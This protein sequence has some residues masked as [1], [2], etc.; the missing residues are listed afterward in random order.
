MGIYAIRITLMRINYNLNQP[1]TNKLI[2]P[3]WE[4]EEQGPERE[5]VNSENYKQTTRTQLNWKKNKY[6]N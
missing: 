4:I 5:E 3:I 6:Y 2:T 1:L